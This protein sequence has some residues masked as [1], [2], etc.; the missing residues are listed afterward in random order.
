[1]EK[2]TRASVISRTADP[3]SLLMEKVFANFINL[4]INRCWPRTALSSRTNVYALRVKKQKNG[5]LIN[6]LKFSALA[7][8]SVS[9]PEVLPSSSLTPT[10]GRD[11]GAVIAP[12]IGGCKK[13]GDLEALK[14]KSAAFVTVAEDANGIRPCVRCAAKSRTL[15]VQQRTNGRSQTRL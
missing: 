5:M 3:D 8:A 1:M 10:G 13:Q 6:S 14:K 15:L 11:F 4:Q 12:S 2:I 7:E 9:V